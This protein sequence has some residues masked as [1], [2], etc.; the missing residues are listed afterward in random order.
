MF[1]FEVGS[2]LNIALILGVVLT[3]AALLIWMERRV[4]GFFQ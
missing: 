1:T 4:L 3:L 2:L